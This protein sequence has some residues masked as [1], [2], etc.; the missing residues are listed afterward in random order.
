MN[1]LQ[2]NSDG[3]GHVHGGGKTTML[4]M[5][6]R[7]EGASDCNNYIGSKP[8]SAGLTTADSALSFA[9]ETRDADR[10]LISPLEGGGNNGGEDGGGDGG[11]SRSCIHKTGG[12][13]GE[14]DGAGKFK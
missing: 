13:A 3:D 5:V 2:S 12:G 11:R 9:L 14:E 8:S 6:Q 10:R 7:G 4:V 1:I